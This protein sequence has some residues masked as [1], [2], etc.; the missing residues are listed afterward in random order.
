MLAVAA[1]VVAVVCVL[2]QHSSFRM[3]DCYGTASH[4]CALVTSTAATAATAAA[5]ATAATAATTN[6][7]ASTDT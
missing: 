3:L 7:T 1:P 2:Q 4:T 5:A 6:A